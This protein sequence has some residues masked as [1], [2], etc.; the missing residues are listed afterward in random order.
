MA[1]QQY[2]NHHYTNYAQSNYPY[3]N[4]YP[5]IIH[6]PV[7]VPVYYT[8]SYI[9]PDTS[10]LTSNGVNSA[11]FS[12]NGVNPDEFN[13]YTVTTQYYTPYS[14]TCVPIYNPQPFQQPEVYQMT[15]TYQ[16]KDGTN[17]EDTTNSEDSTGMTHKDHCDRVKKILGWGAVIL[18]ILI[19]TGIVVHYKG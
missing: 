4:S 15:E 8:N 16:N 10:T 3:V 13:P 11:T 14:D 5:P 7:K 6:T 12:H 1:S 19:I 9:P 18:I 2:Y 17:S